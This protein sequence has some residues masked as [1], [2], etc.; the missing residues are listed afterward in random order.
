[1]ARHPQERARMGEAGARL[2]VERF[3]WDKIAAQ[4]MRLFEQLLDER[5]AC[6]PMGA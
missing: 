4:T 3:G 6:R 5:T 1:M 2:A